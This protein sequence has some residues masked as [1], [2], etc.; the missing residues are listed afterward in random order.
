MNI[1]LNKMTTEEK[2]GQLVQIPP[3]FYIKDLKDELYGPAIELGL[4][5]DQIYNTGSVLGIGS[6]EEMIEVQQKYLENNRLGIPLVFMADIIHGYETIFPIPLGMASSFNKELVETAARVSAI[7]AQTSGIHVTFSPM[8]DISRDPRWGRV[9]E[10]FGEDPYLNYSL[11]A[12]MVKGYQGLNLKNE[13]NIAAC[14]KHFAGYALSEAG[15][16]YNTV[17]ISEYN[18]K[19]HFLDGYRGAIDAGAKLVMTSF[20]LFEGIPATINEHLIKNILRKDLNF[21]GVVISDYN[22]IRETIIHGVSENDKEAAVNAI[23]ASLDIE[24]V[25]GTYIKEL[26]SEFDNGN[27]PM[28]I[29][30][31]ATLRVLNLKKDLGLFDNPYKGV[32]R[33]KH[34]LLVKSKE[35][36]EIAHKAANESIVLLKNNDNLLPINKGTKVYLTGP[37]MK[38]TNLNGAWSWHGNQL[39]NDTLD[40]ILNKNLNVSSLEESEVIIYFGG[41]KSNES[42][43]AKSK[44][45]IDFNYEQLSEIENYKK[46]GK[47]IILIIS[48][49]R[50][51]VLE[52]VEKYSDAILQTWFLGTKSAVSIYD[53]LIGVNNPSGKLPMSFP[54][55]VGQI[56]LY[57]NSLPTGRP[58]ND[59]NNEYTSV[60]IDSKNSPLYP[61]GY[62]LSYSKFIYNNL[63]LEKNIIDENETVI[64]SVDITN[65]SKLPGFEIVQLYVRDLF[66]KV[67]R[68]LLEMKDFKKVWF[69]SNETKTI[70]FEINPSMFTYYDRDLNKRIDAGEF[71]LSIGTS[72]DSLIKT[73]INYIGRTKTI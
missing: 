2:L 71:E 4:S 32:S 65:E 38:E 14:V 73:S 69:E 5:I 6:P 16:D 28:S 42:G 58:K 29:L 63:F 52:S 36:L 17:D 60:Y 70:K 34:D 25:T 39:D 9:M 67:S 26:T 19:Q 53:T 35:H 31:E 12:A 64:I 68:P 59:Y 22:G 55:N 18:L 10:G 30:N 50:P 47:K 46:L 13:G 48:S 40:F 21:D 3:F 72:S 41:E 44:T 62:G 33:K 15:R 51:L 37:N 23:N 24:M 66:A 49:G 27:L 61:F 1:L 20:N 56:P 54:R 57:Y 45:N 7:E 8:G 11:A 43:E